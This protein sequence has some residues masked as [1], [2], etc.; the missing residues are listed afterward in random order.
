[1]QWYNVKLTDINFFKEGLPGESF[2]FLL[3]LRRMKKIFLTIAVVAGI[4]V[5]A[6]AVHIY[7]ATR[8]HIDART[9]Y[10]ARID[11]HQPIDQ[12]D[13]ERIKAWL[14]RQKGIDRVQVNPRWST[15]V[16]TYVPL[17][18]DVN[19]IVQAFK[20]SLLYS[21]AVRYLP[22]KEQMKGRCPVMH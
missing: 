11:L 19:G 13:A 12:T 17:T 1:V 10:M 5:A 8:P 22:S 3:F 16:F 15:A 4:L 21:N 20:T 2:F 6:L 14:L 9:R 7:L 18:T